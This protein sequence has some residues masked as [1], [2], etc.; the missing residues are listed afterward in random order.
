[1]IYKLFFCIIFNKGGV[2]IA[3]KITINDIAKL[4]NT[5]KTTV[6][7]Y[8]N[9]KFEKMSEATKNKIEKVIEETN[10]RPSLVARSL[11]SKN[12]KLIGVL[13]G[14]I[15]NSFSNQIVKGIEAS[16]SEKGYQIIVGNSDYNKE[17][18]ESYLERMMS[19][20]IDGLIIQPSSQF[21]KLTKKIS[22]KGIPT[23]FF[24]SK[25][26]D[27]KT[28]WVKTNNYE[29]TY[30]AIVK[31]IEKGYEDFYM[32][33]A[34]PQLIS[35]RLER[36]S[37]FIDA[38]ADH[39]KTYEFLTIENDKVKP[40]VIADF[41]D[42]RLDL[43]K[44]SL[45]FVPNCWALPTVFLAMKHHRKRMPNIGLLGFD[46]MEWVNF[47]SPAISTIV[48]PAFEEG[49]EAANIL[50]DQIENKNNI[51]G[52]KVLDCYVNWNESTL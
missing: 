21:R 29:A 28:K 32:I 16:A 27:M 42:E 31:C 30:D 49:M 18:E 13:I 38:L 48:Q 11:N 10:Y 33:T 9:G 43:N 5:S 12:S 17:R 40:E 46:N 36:T 37:G 25:L 22:E 52:Q 51:I 50:I 14:D 2:F 44:K 6:S 8:L 3:H 41:L 20:R 7:F 23:V 1:M 26:Y 39:S 34:D 19:M 47:S 45:V 15:T 35:T 4:S 24:D